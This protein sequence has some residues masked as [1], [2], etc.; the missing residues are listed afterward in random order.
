MQ[1]LHHEESEHLTRPINVNELGIMV[2]NRNLP[3]L[4][5]PKTQ[6]I[7]QSKFYRHYKQHIIPILFKLIPRFLKKKKQGAGL[8]CVQWIRIYLAVQ[9]RWVRSLPRKFSLMPW[10][11]TAQ[12]PQPL[13]Q[14]SRVH[15]PQQ[16]KTL[17]TGAVNLNPETTPLN[18]NQTVPRSTATRQYPAN[19]NP[20]S[21]FLAS[22]AIQTGLPRSTATRQY[23]P[24]Q[25]RGRLVRQQR[26]SP[27]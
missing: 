6:R 11:N 10:S 25:A 20:D 24:T 9:G 17:Q 12:A 27:A 21:K 7:L 4:K 15:A 5:A 1:K 18:C 14:C 13:S 19:R 2:E 3:L 8:P 22:T 16:E 26:P 23:P